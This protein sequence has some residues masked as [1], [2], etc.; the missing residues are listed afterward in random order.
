MQFFCMLVY[1][2]ELSAPLQFIRKQCCVVVGHFLL[3]TFMMH[4]I[5]HLTYNF[6]GTLFVVCIFWYLISRVH[7]T[8]LYCLWCSSQSLI[9]LTLDTIHKKS[10]WWQRGSE[11]R[12]LTYTLV[13]ELQFHENPQFI[14]SSSSSPMRYVI[15]K[16]IDYVYLYVNF[17]S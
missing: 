6:G 10:N 2:W 5:L 1:G 7:D 9:L 14:W 4:C 8:L 13:S 16:M 12:F 17:N 11:L 15:V 3:Y